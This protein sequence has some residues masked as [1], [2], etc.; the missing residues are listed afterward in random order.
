ME[1]RSALKTFLSGA[2]RANPLITFALASV[3]TALVA[4]PMAIAA[5][6]A[7]EPPNIAPVERLIVTAEGANAAPLHDARVSGQVM[8][9]YLGDG[10]EAVA[11][12]LTGPDDSVIAER[13]DGEGPSFD[14]FLDENNVPIAFDTARVDD[15]RYTV[16]VSIRQED[17]KE[18]KTAA[19]FDIANTDNG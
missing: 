14:L 11:F 10:V 9:S 19:A 12:S 15:G 16:L 13:V 5:V 2:A 3:V 17:G 6:S 8:V 7:E 4:V 18:A 1:E